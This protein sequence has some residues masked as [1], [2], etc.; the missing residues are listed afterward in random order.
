[1]SVEVVMAFTVM[2]AISVDVLKVV[3][4]GTKDGSVGGGLCRMHKV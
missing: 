4:G 2:V 3:G 1:M